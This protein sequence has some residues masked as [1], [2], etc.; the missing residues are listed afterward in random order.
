MWR[1]VSDGCPICKRFLGSQHRESRSQMQS[2]SET[3]P[4]IILVPDRAV[5]D[6]RFRYGVIYVRKR[7]P[8]LAPIPLGDFMSPDSNDCS[9]WILCELARVIVRRWAFSRGQSISLSPPLSILSSKVGGSGCGG[10]LVASGPGGRV[11]SRGYC[12]ESCSSDCTRVGGEWRPCSQSLPRRR[13]AC[14]PHRFPELRM[15]HSCQYRQNAVANGIHRLATSNALLPQ[16]PEQQIVVQE[17][18]AN[19][20]VSR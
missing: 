10:S 13:H 20:W 11:V 4:L 19:C 6:V 14:L 18:E 17:E 16:S 2:S 7:I 8:S 12:R 15:R 5:Q 3:W 1:G 9:S